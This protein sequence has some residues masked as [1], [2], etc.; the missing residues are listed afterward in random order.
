VLHRAS[1]VGRVFWDIAIESFGLSPNLGRVTMGPSAVQTT[2]ESLRHKELICRRET[3]AFAGAKEYVFRHAL[4]HEVVYESVLEDTRQA[5]HAQAAAWLIEQSGERAG[6]FAAVIASHF[7][8]A[9]R[10]SLAAEWYGRAGLQAKATWAPRTAI[11]YFELALSYLTRTPPEDPAH[12]AIRQIEWLSGLG[13]ALVA[14]ARFAEAEEVYRQ[15]LAAADNSADLI[16]AAQAWNGLAFVQERQG[17]NRQSAEA[18]GHAA[19]LASRAGPSHA[20]QLSLARALFLQGWAHYRLGNPTQVL[21]RGA[22]ALQICKELGGRNE[23]V[24]CLKL[25]AVG[26][27]LQDEFDLAAR[28]FEHGLALARSLGDRRNVSA[29]LSNLGETARLRGEYADAVRYYQEAI[30]IAHEIGSIESELLYASNLGGARVALGTPAEL[31]AAE[32]DLRRI[33]EAGQPTRPRQPPPLYFSETHRFLAEALLGEHRLAEAFDHAFAAVQ[34]ALRTEN[35]EHLAGGWRTLALCLHSPEQEARL[36]HLP[37]PPGVT[38]TSM[39][40]CFEQSLRMCRALGSNKEYAR[41]LQAWARL[42]RLQGRHLEA[43]RKETE[44][45]QLSPQSPTPTAERFSPSASGLSC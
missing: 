7:E 36:A 44:A 32:H 43:Q 20:A 27:L 17:A 25:M 5:C 41:T 1:V 37:V 40:D 2:L 39:K 13:E 28:F 19:D 18:A 21:E 22:R 42:D 3:S 8:H 45:A 33:L 35:Q 34:L 24:N 14:Q 10:L 12:T 16:A 26:H 23:L 9:R 38:V 6:E 11:S 4:L 31:T 30:S 29:M 15:M